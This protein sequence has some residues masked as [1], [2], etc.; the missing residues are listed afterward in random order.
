MGIAIDH[1]GPGPP[2]TGQGGRARIATVIVVSQWV[3][4][5]DDF[6]QDDFRLH[7]T[8]GQQFVAGEYLY[9]IGHTPYPPFWGMVVPPF[10]AT[11]AV[12]ACAGLPHRRV[13][14][15][16]ARHHA[17]SPDAPA[18]ATGTGALV[19]VDNTGTG[20]VQPVRHPRIAGMRPESAHGRPGLGGLA[21]WRR[22]RDG[23]AGAVPGLAIAMKCTQALFVPY[24]ILKRQWRMVGATTA[25]TLAFFGGAGCPARSRTL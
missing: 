4:V 5:F 1:L 10:A 14:A 18:A 25:F 15:G 19:L 9:Q 23:L 2:T 22:G 21:F 13:F 11:E 24:F 8:F 6:A 17:R 7:W 20:S 16:G 12:V 3:R